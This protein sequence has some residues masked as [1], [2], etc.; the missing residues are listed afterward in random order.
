MASFEFPTTPTATSSTSILIR[1]GDSGASRRTGIFFRSMIVS[2]DWRNFLNSGAFPAV[3]HRRNKD[4][5]R[6]VH[7]NYLIFYRIGAEQ[8]D[9]MHVIHGAQDYE[10]WLFGPE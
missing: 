3:P 7:G 4:I 5:R 10:A 8:V 6:R 9:V 2:P 1:A